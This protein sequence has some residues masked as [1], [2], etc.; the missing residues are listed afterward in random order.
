MSIASCVF[1]AIFSALVRA[2][3]LVGLHDMSGTVNDASAVMV[4]ACV[5]VGR[6]TGFLR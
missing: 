2:H 4:E 5:F 6:R 3:V 1:S